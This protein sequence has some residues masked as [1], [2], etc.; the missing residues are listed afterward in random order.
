MAVVLETRKTSRDTKLQGKNLT[1]LEHNVKIFVSQKEAKK[2]REEERE[3]KRKC[4][5]EKEKVREEE[6]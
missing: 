4:K 5:S 2:V 1:C 3:R 6:R